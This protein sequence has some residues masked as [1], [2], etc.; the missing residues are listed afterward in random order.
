MVII[1]TV[2]CGPSFVLNDSGYTHNR[3]VTSTFIL[4]MSKSNSRKSY[5]S[6]SK[7]TSRKMYMK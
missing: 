7:S 3:A 4:Y 1:T 6:K 5:S 2:A